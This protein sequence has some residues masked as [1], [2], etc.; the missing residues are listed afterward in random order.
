MRRL[1][2]LLPL[3]LLGCDSL[4]GPGEYR[5]EYIVACTQGTSEQNADELA[6]QLSRQLNAPL[7]RRWP[8]LIVMYSRPTGVEVW[9]GQSG[10]TIHVDQQ[11]NDL[12]LRVLSKPLPATLAIQKTIESDVASSHCVISSFSTGHSPQTKLGASYGR[13]SGSTRRAVSG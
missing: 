2:L 7:E 3:V 12:P 9:Y 10:Y 8:G 5:A 11:D 13:R 1:T 6:F 4:L